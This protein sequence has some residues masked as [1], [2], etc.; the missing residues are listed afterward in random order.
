MEDEP[1]DYDD[2]IEDLE[3]LNIDES[4]FSD[5]PIFEIEE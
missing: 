3:F 4:D 1:I 5:L 2:L